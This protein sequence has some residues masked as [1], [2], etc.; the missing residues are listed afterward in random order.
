M[1][2]RPLCL[3]VLLLAMTI[4]VAN[5]L[6]ISW[7]WRSPVGDT[8]F[9][10]AA[11]SDTQHIVDAEGIVWRQESKTY[12][13]NQVITYLYLKQTNLYIDSKKYPIR[14]IKCKIEGTANEFFG[15]TLRIRGELVLPQEPG[16]PGEFDRVSYER[17]RKTDFYLENIRQ[18]DVISQAGKISVWMEKI[19]RK[20]ENIICEIFPQKEAGVLMAILLGE[21]D[22]LEEEIQSGFQAAGISHVMA[23]SGLHISM[24][25]VGLWNALK[26]IGM[27]L[28]LSSAGSIALLIGYG[29]LIGNP[30]TAVRA[31][32]MFGMMLAAKILGRTYDFLSALAMAGILLLLD[33]PD[34]LMDSG[35][36]LSFATVVGMG[37]YVESQT[38]LWRSL[39]K[40]R[41]GERIGEKIIAGCSI[42]IFMLPVVLHAFYQVS[43]IGIVCNL[44]VLPLMPV[45][46]GSGFLALLLGCQEI[47]FGSVAGIP[48]YG[49]VR[50]YEY[51]GEIAECIP[52]GIWTPG[53]PSLVVIVIYYAVLAVSCILCDKVKEKRT[54]EITDQNEVQRRKGMVKKIIIVKTATIFLSLVFMAAPWNRENSITV[55]DVGQGDGIVLQAGKT[56]ILMDGG[57]SSREKVGKYVILPFLKHQG[58]SN[59]EAI[60]LTHPDQDHINGAM[61][62]LEESK[63]GWLSVGKI[64]MPVWMEETEEGKQICLLAQEAGVFCGFLEKGDEISVGKTKI[65]V[66]HPDG[67]NYSQDENTGSIVCTWEIGGTKVLLTGDL[68]VE[69]EKKIL[70]ALPE[71]EILKA[72]HHGSNGSTSEEF[73]KKV[74][75]KAALV[76]CGKNNRYG[77]PG[78][79]TLERLWE[80]QCEIWRTDRQGALTVVMK[81]EG[82]TVHGFR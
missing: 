53:K 39:R 32:I 21:K 46:L 5:W 57:S 2:K 45:V 48:A 50:M 34:L 61:E 72:A 31:L 55:L 65:K 63:K 26:W 80:N 18:I 29:V 40:G 67:E 43:V 78:G 60:L 70:D 8:P 47:A 30:T 13:E 41:K 12:K 69:G 38:E 56:Q 52:K 10:L 74:N 3:M 42:W 82:W 35:F 76:S 19:R 71:C 51:I 66:L 15:C 7:I 28:P 23:I 6:G 16:N 64:F 81:G 49:I 24:L 59:L 14:T 17:S 54:G 68:P 22:N 58:I 77:H 62:V 37:T 44:L 73:L 79:E 27:P 11:E 4:L 1:T 75:P 9:V 25:G 36:Q 33:N 20:C